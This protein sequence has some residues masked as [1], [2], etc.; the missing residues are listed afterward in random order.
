MGSA[1]GEAGEEAQERRG[2]PGEEGALREGPPPSRRRQAAFNPR[3]PAP[4]P[5]LRA[6]PPPRTPPGTRG[7][8]RRRAQLLPMVVMTVMAK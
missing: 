7:A 6:Q 2:A 3:R 5:A 1:R 8:G 4:S